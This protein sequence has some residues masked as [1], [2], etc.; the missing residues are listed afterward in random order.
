MWRAKGI[1][2]PIQYFFQ[3][4]L[5]DIIL[6]TDTHF[7]LEKEDYKE[8]TKGFE[9]GVLYMSSVTR[10]VKN[11]LSK[12]KRTLGNRFYDFQY[13]DLGCGKG[14]TVIIYSKLYRKKARHK[15][16]GI[17][18][19][20]PLID[21]ANNNFRITGVSETSLAI[22]GDARQFKKHVTSRNLI[23]YLYNPFG[24]DILR[25][26]LES[27]KE[28]EVY[29]IYSDPANQKLVE[30]MGFNLLYSKKGNYPNTTISI[31]LRKGM[32]L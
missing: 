4:H 7:R 6:S 1:R 10:E 17:D 21:I 19:Y 29:L 23:L 5:F 31:F 30:D 18:Y 8:Q 11:S 27:C 32:L 3:N 24:E 12:I 14:K 16:I 26:V 20:K 15:A 25:D 28:N 22:Y 9:S 13:F 2:L